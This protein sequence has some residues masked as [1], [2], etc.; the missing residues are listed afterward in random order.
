MLF[1]LLIRRGQADSGLWV[2]RRV[3]DGLISQTGGPVA[4]PLFSVA[5]PEGLR[6]TGSLAAAFGTRL[7]PRRSR[8]R[9]DPHAGRRCR[10]GLILHPRWDCRDKGMRV[11]V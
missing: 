9:H 2:T 10:A 11:S 5:V 7:P 4:S 3:P 1:R 6:A 8:A